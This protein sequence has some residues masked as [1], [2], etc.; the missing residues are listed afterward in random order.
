MQQIIQ[1]AV[2]LLQN[3]FTLPSNG[4]LAGGALANTINKLKWGGKCVINDIDIFILD[5]VKEFNRQDNINKGIPQSYTTRKLSTTYKDVDSY[6]EKIFIN[7][8]SKGGDYITIKSSVRDGIY[9]NVIFDTN[10]LDYNMFLETFD[11]NCTQV[12]YDLKTKKAYWTN[13]F[14]EY[15]NTKELKVTLPNTP[16]HTILRILKK[17]D[18]LDATLNIKSEFSFL[19]FVNLDKIIGRKKCWF[20]DRYFKI[21]ETYKEEISQY[22][23]LKEERCSNE[24]VDPNNPNLKI[25]DNFTIW[26]LHPKNW[27][28][29]LPNYNYPIASASND[30]FWDTNIPTPTAT[31]KYPLCQKYASPTCYSDFITDFITIDDYNYYWRNIKVDERKREIWRTLQAFYK[32]NDYLIGFPLENLNHYKKDILSLKSMIEKYPTLLKWLED[33][34][35][36]KQIEF[37]RLLTDICGETPDLYYVLNHHVKMINYDSREDLKQKMLIF[38]IRYRKAIYE[39]LK[40]LKTEKVSLF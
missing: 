7:K 36:I 10:K 28:V 11:I 21:Y 39:D 16:S 19:T 34:S 1:K 22:F 31:Y 38:K 3:K 35:L 8:V 24:K 9:N 33:V 23:D 20:G 5:E 30:E 2:E 27:E 25:V 32:H 15:I 17:R 6:D 4:F 14:E 13:D 40:K 37:I 29:N 18:E 26:K 12:G